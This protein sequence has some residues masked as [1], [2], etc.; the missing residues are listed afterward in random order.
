MPRGAV[1]PAP[2]RAAIL[3]RI[4]A[5]GFCTLTL[6]DGHPYYHYA[7]GV[8]IRDA[9]GKLLTPL[10]FKSLRLIPDRGDTLFKGVPAQAWRAR[11]PSDGK[12]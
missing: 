10:A 7:D 11:K 2:H 4:A 3:R 1:M 8:A 9:A 5:G 6:H 12:G